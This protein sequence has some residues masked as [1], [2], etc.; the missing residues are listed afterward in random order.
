MVVSEDR[1][2]ALVAVYK[3]LNDV[4]CE[5]RRLKLH[6]LAEA[7]GVNYMKIHQIETGKINPQNIAL[8]TAIKLSKALDC[9]PEDIL[10]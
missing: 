9:K 8:K 10:K 6:G 5:Y 7:S 4:N 1:R 2:Q 3:V